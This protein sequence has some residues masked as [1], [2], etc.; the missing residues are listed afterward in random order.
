MDI[1]FGDELFL[2]PYYAANDPK[3]ARALI[4]YRIQRLAGAQANAET[5]GEAGAMY[6][7]Q[8]GLYGDE[9]AQVIHLNTVDQSWIPD[10]SR[11][12]RHVSL[13]IAYD[14]WVYT[15]YDWGC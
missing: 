5:E 1:F 8:S 4:Q 12:Q 3:A 10:N 7:W 15:P 14:L 13:A 2:V 11:L 6:P 9:Q